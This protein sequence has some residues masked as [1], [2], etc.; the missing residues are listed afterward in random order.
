MFAHGS[1]T[2]IEFQRRRAATWNAIRWWLLLA[3]L[4][5][6]TLFVLPFAPAPSNISQHLRVGVSLIV[7]FL[8]CV[9]VINIQVRRIY[10]CPSCNKLP[11]KTIYGWRSELGTEARDIQWNPSICPN[12]GAPL[13]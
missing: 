10:R 11:I 12:C 1:S 8:V 7:G 5:I 6:A 3:V 13:R 2:V 4:S 9:G